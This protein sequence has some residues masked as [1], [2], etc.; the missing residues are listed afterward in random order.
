MQQ[1]F[2][3]CFVRWPALKLFL[4][5]LSGAERLCW[6]SNKIVTRYFK[7]HFLALFLVF[8]SFFVAM[9]AEANA[10]EDGYKKKVCVFGENSSDSQLGQLVIFK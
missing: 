8:F 6:A 1:K 3:Y 5:T 4:L 2:C 9:S 10:C 7:L